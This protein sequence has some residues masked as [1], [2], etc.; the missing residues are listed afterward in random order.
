MDSDKISNW[1]QVAPNIGILAG[2]ILVGLQMQQNTDLLRMQLLKDEATSYLSTE[3]T[4]LGEN[5]A[6]VYAKSIT[7]PKS[8]TVADMRIE[9]TMLWS[10]GVF[11]WSNTYRLYEFGLVEEEQWKSEV[12]RDL[13]FLYGSPYG[14]A[15]WD[16]ISADLEADYADPEQQAFVPKALKKYIDERV[17][18]IRPQVTAL[19]HFAKIQENLDKY[20]EEKP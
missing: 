18:K 4:I 20:L 15:W 5:Y 3:S 17:K 6:E 9:D 19:N 13:P 11:R 2:L 7:D 16:K 10:H 14:R 8:M 1:I 12:T